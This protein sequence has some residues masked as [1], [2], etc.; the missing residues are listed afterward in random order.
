[1]IKNSANTQSEY[2]IKPYFLAERN[3]LEDRLLF[4]A[5]GANLVFYPIILYG[6]LTEY[7]IEKALVYAG[8]YAST[9]LLGRIANRVQAKGIKRGI[10]KQCK[11]GL[12]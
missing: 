6:L 8:G 5:T 10:K 1:M 12:I 9:T 11:N 3:S 4:A 7:S 2:C